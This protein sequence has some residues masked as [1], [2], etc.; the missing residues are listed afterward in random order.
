ML[1]SVVCKVMEGLIKDKL[2]QYFEDSNLFTVHQH[3][4]MA[5]RSCLTNLLETFE[6]WSEALEKD[7][8]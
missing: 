5:G 2:V 8:A 4:F 1:T 3:G 6:S 7:A